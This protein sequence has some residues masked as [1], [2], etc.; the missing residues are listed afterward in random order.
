MTDIPDL[1]EFLDKQCYGFDDLRRIVA[2]LRAPGGCPWDAEQTHE[3]IRKNF[4][5]ETYEAIEAINKGDDALL[6]EELGDV[7]LQVALHTEIARERGAFGWEQ[8]TDGICRKLIERHPHVFGATQVTGVGD[9]LLNWDAIK[10]RSKGQA[11]TGQAM[12]SVPR[13]LPALMR[14]EKLQK[15]AAKI[16]IGENDLNG[17]MGALLFS[18]VQVARLLPGCDAELVLAEAADKFLEQVKAQESA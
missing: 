17:A 14:A 8:V 10:R 1:P 11:S 12:E 15:K 5:E 2:I 13:E 3:S 16:G 6:C 18:A 9:V 7:L 4:I